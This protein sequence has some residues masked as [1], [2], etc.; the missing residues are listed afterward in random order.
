[1]SKTFCQAPWHDIHIVTDGGFQGCC[2]MGAG[3]TSGR[4]KTDGKDVT[5]ADGLNAGVNSDTAK[6]LRLALMND[7]WHPECIRCMDEEKAGMK[8]MR[9]FYNERWEKR[10]DYDDA[11]A[12]TDADT[13]AVPD[14]HVPF[15]YDIQLGN[16]CNLK[17]RICGPAL[18]SSWV[19]DEQKMK[20]LGSK[21]RQPIAPG[22]ETITIEHLGG[23]KYSYSPDPF[24][25]ANSDLFWEQ[26]S[27]QKDKIE[28][29]YL[30]GGEPMMI[31]RHFKFLKECVESGDSKHIVLQYD[32]NLTNLPQKVMEYWK[33]FKTLEIGFSIDGMGPELEY[34]RNPVKWDH[35][36]KNIHKL[37]AFAKENS[38]VKLTDSVTVSVYNILHILDY[39]EWKVKAGKYDFDYLWQRH[40]KHFGV[41]PLHSPHYL[42][43]RVMPFKAKREISKQYIKWQKKMNDWIDSI[44]DYTDIQNK[45]SLRESVNTYVDT[46]I[47]FMNSEDSSKHMHEFWSFTN[48]LDVIRDES[49][50]DVFPDLNELLSD[51][52]E[53]P[54][55]WF[56]P[57]ERFDKE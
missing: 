14:D 15:F 20:G 42:N 44:D 45:K 51:Y 2:V 29:L 17:C 9:N 33:E 54:D 25:W 4:L 53:K 7:K 16:L 38:N 34:M 27:E 13:G 43:V 35:I 56:L 26:M 12:I 3:P 19:P 22:R 1:M 55:W 8:S 11:V 39:I 57:T 49:F 6:S 30:I 37:E 48:D 31:Q 36:L 32:T 28:H 50:A 24:A 41:H 21:W 18:S 47:S 5:I 52:H 10:F 23:K 46:W 40:G